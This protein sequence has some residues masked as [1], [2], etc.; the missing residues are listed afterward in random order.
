VGGFVGVAFEDVVE[1][2]FLDGLGVDFIALAGLGF[3]GG[4]AGSNSRVVFRFSQ[5]TSPGSPQSMVTKT[6]TERPIFDERCNA[7]SG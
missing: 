5:P 4:V 7:T 2:A 3:G 1:L 6:G